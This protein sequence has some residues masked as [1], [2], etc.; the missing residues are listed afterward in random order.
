MKS[1]NK[2]IQLKKDLVETKTPGRKFYHPV[3]SGKRK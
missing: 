2:I 1:L 3:Y